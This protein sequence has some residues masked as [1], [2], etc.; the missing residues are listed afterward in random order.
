MV[1]S[2]LWSVRLRYEVFLSFFEL[3]CRHHVKMVNF[4]QICVL[5]FYTLSSVS[6]AGCFIFTAIQ[7]EI[8]KLIV[9]EIDFSKVYHTDD[10]WWQTQTCKSI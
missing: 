5:F 7:K 6:A 9:F 3:Y 1:A 10:T 8:G 4:K 2:G